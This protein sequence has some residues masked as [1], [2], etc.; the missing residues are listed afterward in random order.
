MLSRKK[1]VAIAVIF[2]L[3]ACSA[4]L[5]SPTVKADSPRTIIVPDDFPTIK[6]AV[7][8]ASAGDTVYVKAGTY[9]IAAEGYF[10]YYS[11]KCLAIFKPISLIGENC[12]NTVINATI[13]HETIVYSGIQVDADNVRISGFTIIS[14]RNSVYILGN[15]NTL[16][17]N[18]IKLTSEGGAVGVYNG[19]VSSNI[20]EGVGV[21][22]GVQA[23]KN[24]IISNNIIRNF[25]VGISSLIGET[26]QSIF[27]NTIA[28]NT[29]G[30]GR[31]LEAP[32]LLYHNNIENNSQN[33]IYLTSNKDINA[34]YNYWGTTNQTEIENSIY[35]NKNDSSLGTVNFM[36]FL[37]VPNPDALPIQLSKQTVPELSLL[38]ILPLLLSVVSVAL[39]LRYRK[40]VKKLWLSPVKIVLR[41]PIYF[42]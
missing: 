29:I 35:D 11:F 30:L 13:D 37:T 12:Q 5:Q 24:S 14:N 9:D 2:V 18:I 28:N 10:S 34:S 36:P 39:V 6:K 4:T 27:D 16:T 22:K 41:I 21:G 15:N 7:D 20:I 33:S 3:I 42:S 31:Y 26:N 19:N 1:T 38:T 32:A 17:G 40:Q 23:N 8:N 25:H